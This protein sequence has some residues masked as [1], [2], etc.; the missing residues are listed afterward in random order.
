M[1]LD[2]QLLAEVVAH[3]NDDGPRLVLADKLTEA[4]D[5]RGEFIV[6]SCLL[7]DPGLVPPRRRELKERADGLLREH[8]SR[9]VASAAGLRYVVRRGFVDQIDSDAAALLPRAASLFASEPVTRLTLERAGDSLLALANAGAFARVLKLTIR[10]QLED[11]GARTLASALARRDAPLESLNVGSCEIGADGAA[12][13]ASALAGCKSLALTGNPIGDDGALAL[14]KAKALSALEAL[15]L[16][17]TDLTDQGLYAL[18]KGPF[19]SLERLAVA[20]NEVTQD[21]L[22]AIARSK[23]LKR[24]RWLEYTDEEEGGQKVAVRGA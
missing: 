4:G 7:A 2:P 23:K 15:Y 9:W 14:A 5:P 18:S 16:S 13:L 11:A 8:G 1:S 21:G 22:G 19:T 3:P 17:D 12:A 20:R 6:A 24:L 10:G